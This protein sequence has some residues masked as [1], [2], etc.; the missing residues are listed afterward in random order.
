MKLL[1]IVLLLQ[2]VFK[3]LKQQGIRQQTGCGK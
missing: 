2:W 3:I 1:L